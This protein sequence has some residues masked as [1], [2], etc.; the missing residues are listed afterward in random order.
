MSGDFASP[1]PHLEHL[2]WHRPV[3]I[4]RPIIIAAF[5]GWNDAGDA[6]T[7]A[8]RHLGASWGAETFAHIDPEVF[9]DFTVT[10][11]NVR[12]TDD[13]QRVID[14]PTNELSVAT[15]RPGLEVITLTGTEPQLRW[16]TFCEQLTGL[17]QHVD[18]R[19]VVTLGALLA[20]VPHTRPV[21]IYGAAYDDD[22]MREFD[23]MPSHYEGPTG[24]VG[25][26]H[27]E[28]HD[29][30]LRSASL[31]AAVPTYVPGAPSPKAALAL[32]ERT[33]VLLEATTPTEVLQAETAEYVRQIDELVTEDEETADYVATLEAAYDD[34]EDLRGDG[35]SLID[36]VER[37]L[38]G[39]AL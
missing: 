38:R 25:A 37:F 19:L 32:V 9:Y 31:W 8:V 20:E 4:D 5:G 7:T 35:A 34:T 23:L 1:T 16:R 27:A 22:V 18:A 10:R 3:S 17:A 13:G 29:A 12:F 28:W 26:L 15:A 24:I 2:R 14:W 33:S 6:A 11:P 21:S 39:D 36:E 30:G